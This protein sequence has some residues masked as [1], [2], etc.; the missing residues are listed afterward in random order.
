MS[1][2]L[3]VPHGGRILVKL[4]NRQ[5][6]TRI[7]PGGIELP[8]TA[9]H[10]EDCDGVVLAVSQQSGYALPYWAALRIIGSIDCGTYSPPTTQELIELCAQPRECNV[11]VGD[12]ILFDVS[13]SSQAPGGDDEY[14][15]D[16]DHIYAVVS[17]EVSSIQ[18]TKV[19]QDEIGYRTNG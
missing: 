12:R 11:K 16:E 3:R 4:S 1:D 6:E 15:I 18:L 19:S 13:L 8:D 7:S 14:L 2:S 17:P 9:E 5:E 10:V